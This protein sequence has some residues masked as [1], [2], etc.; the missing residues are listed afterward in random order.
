MTRVRD[1]KTRRKRYRMMGKQHLDDNAEMAPPDTRRRAIC[2]LTVRTQ[3]VTHKLAH[4]VHR[5]QPP[6]LRSSSQNAKSAT[7]RHSE[8]AAVARQ[9]VAC[10]KSRNTPPRWQNDAN[11]VRWDNAEHKGTVN[12]ARTRPPH[13]SMKP[14]DQRKR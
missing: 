4:R 12:R 11:A 6:I 10:H 3:Q 7:A 5:Q 14:R 13:L 2:V 8:N 9:L 1:E